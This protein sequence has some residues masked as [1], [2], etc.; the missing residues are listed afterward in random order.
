MNDF[1]KEQTRGKIPEIIKENLVQRKFR[2][3]P[4][5]RET[6][7]ADVPFFLINA[8]YLNANWSSRFAP[9]NSHFADFFVNDHLIKNV[10]IRH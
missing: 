7:S 6:N 9:S 2:I 3:N 1:V 5:L 10:K 4:K 8:L